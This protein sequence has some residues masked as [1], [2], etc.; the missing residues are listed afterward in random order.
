MFQNNFKNHVYGGRGLFGPP[1]K[2]GIFKIP[3]VPLHKLN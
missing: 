3:P 2:P 1:D